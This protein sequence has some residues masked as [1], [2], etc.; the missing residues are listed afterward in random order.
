[1]TFTLPLGNQ[2]RN[3]SLKA[4]D[5]KIYTLKDFSDYSALVLFFSCNHCPYVLFS[6]PITRKTAEKFSQHNIGFV[7]INSNSAY[8][9]P[10]D[11]FEKMVERMDRYRFPW[12]YLHDETQEVAKTYGAVRTPHFFVFDETR[13]LIYTGRGMDNPLDPEKSS[14]NDLERALNEFTLSK[15]LSR[16]QTNPVGCTIKWQGKRANW[17]PLEA[18]DLL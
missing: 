3:F 5:G 2:A 13:S 16:P 11:S 10:E 1:M 7:A 15:P 18:C 8:R 14:A 6:D 12:V 17:I 4:T 9:E